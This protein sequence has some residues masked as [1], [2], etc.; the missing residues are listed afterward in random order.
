MSSNPNIQAFLEAQEP[1]LLVVEEALNEWSGE[2][3]LQFPALMS[4]VMTKLGWTGE[5][6]EKVA[7]A[8]EP[9]I[10]EFVRN[11][12]DWHVTRGAHGGIMRASEKQ[13]KEAAKAAKEK[14]K[15]E[16]EAEIAKR[17]AAKAEA[18]AIRD[19][20]VTVDA[21]DTDNTNTVSE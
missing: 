6:G 21:V 1:M 7:R 8:K 18:L 2:G 5:D 3:C 17:N 10:R 13:K 11:H 15:S 4:S 14:A 16:L 12:P 20:I 9:I 19:S